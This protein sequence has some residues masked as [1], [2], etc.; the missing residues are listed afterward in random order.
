MTKCKMRHYDLK[1]L[2]RILY[3]DMINSTEETPQIS[4]TRLHKHMK[5]CYIKINGT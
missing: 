2:V 3:D 1:K 5:E 4:Q